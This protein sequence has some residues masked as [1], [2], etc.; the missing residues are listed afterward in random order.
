MRAFPR[1]QPRR[2][3][4][5]SAVETISDF[6]GGLNSADSQFAM[7]SK[8][9][10]VLDNLLVH[11]TYSLMSR[12]GTC[13][14][15]TIPTT[16]VNITA[17]NKALIAFCTDGTIYKIDAS[18]TATVIWNETI[19]NALP[20]NPTGWGATEHIDFEEVSDVLFCTNGADKPV[21]VDTDFNVTYIADL[22][23]GSNI[24][25]P[26]ARFVA[27]A[28]DY[29][30]MADGLELYISARR[31]YSTFVGDADPNDATTFNVGTHVSGGASGITGLA[32]FRNKL[33]VFL[34]T[35]FAVITLGEYDN[36]FHIPRVSDTV[37]DLGLPTNRAMFNTDEDFVFLS[38]AGVD[39]LSQSLLGD[40]F[41]T[42]PAASQIENIMLRTLPKLDTDK[43]FV[44]VD[45][46]NQQVFF[47]LH[48]ADSD[49]L[50]FA[51]SFKARNFSK[52]AWCSI[53][54]WDDFTAGCSGID[55]RTFFVKENK[56][57]QY[58]NDA[59]DGEEY[60][61]DFMAD[62]ETEGNPI[63]IDWELPWI[64]AGSRLRMKRLKR[65]AVDTEGTARFNVQL[66]GD[67]I[68]KD[69]NDEYTPAVEI[70]FDAGNSGEFGAVNKYFGGG[71]RANGQRLFGLPLDF[72]LLKVRVTGEITERL[73]I[74]S[75]SL[76]MMNGGY[77][78]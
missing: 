69:Y 57:Y 61:T 70:T 14:F 43:T 72:K 3:R 10:P 41:E 59:Y 23:S 78:R 39:R 53:K 19:A 44:T 68:Y 47:F 62:A 67:R 27:S 22:A 36:E 66:F 16:I 32:A 65:V 64:D 74:N 52:T 26:I 21:Q 8:F 29:L 42:K 45:K 76:L 37:K 75:I 63:T 49:P 48:S 2:G 30:V 54:G 11:E 4:N 46:I 50:V 35:S 7:Q 24:N 71:R 31:T 13:E 51:M 58:G 60:T 40:R 77:M 18:G 28:N 56:I 25:V 34:G 33:I 17:F 15:S 9:A 5:T 38:N 6:S 73:F 55:N 20:D 12:F 1:M